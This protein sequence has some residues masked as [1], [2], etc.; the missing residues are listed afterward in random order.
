MDAYWVNYDRGLNRV[1]SHGDSVQAVIS[2]LREHFEPSAG[3][4]FFPD[5]ADR[6]LLGTLC[7]SGWTGV[8]VRAYYHYAIRDPH[9][10]VLTY[11]E[12]DVYGGNHP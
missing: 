9:G 2:I 1:A 4:A 8:W 7:D 10:S 6:T 5:G 3:D 12:G 11:V